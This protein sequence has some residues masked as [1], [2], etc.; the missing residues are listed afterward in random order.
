[1]DE[2]RREV[3]RAGQ[4]KTLLAYVIDLL[5]W[6]GCS[7]YRTSPYNKIA[8]MVAVAG[9]SENFGLSSGKFGTPM[10]PQREVIIKNS[11]DADRMRIKL[12]TY[13]QKLG[14]SRGVVV[15]EFL[16]PN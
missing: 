13:N 6:Q 12:N 4:V 2:G 7:P 10:H 14:I 11:E 9:T 5:A 3:K 16:T 1:M 8:W 15:V